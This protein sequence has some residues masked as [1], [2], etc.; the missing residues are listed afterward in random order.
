M[1][2]WSTHYRPIVPAGHCE[3][4]HRP[5]ELSEVVIQPSRKITKGDSSIESGP[6]MVMICGRHHAGR[7]SP[8]QAPRKTTAETARERQGEQLAIF[9]SLPYCK[10]AGRH[11]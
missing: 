3:L 4:C 10:R 6:L 9:D 8:P 11:G 2:R 1:R 5:G 7:G